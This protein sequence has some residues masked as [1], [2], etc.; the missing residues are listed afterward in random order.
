MRARACMQYARG[1]E[2]E[3]SGYLGLGFADMP[4]KYGCSSVAGGEGLQPWHSMSC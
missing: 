1:G 4:R 3:I 2:L